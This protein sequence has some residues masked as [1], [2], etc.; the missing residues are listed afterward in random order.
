MSGV[1]VIALAYQAWYIAYEPQL[2][3][4]KAPSS[5][6]TRIAGIAFRQTESASCAKP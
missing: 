2:P 4:T 6:I 3:T 1:V 5:L